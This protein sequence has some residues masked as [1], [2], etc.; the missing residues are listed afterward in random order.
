MC[1]FIRP[2]NFPVQLTIAPLIGAIAAG[3]PA[4]VKPSESTPRTAVIL[5]K[6]IAD[7]LEPSCYACVQGAIPETEALLKER[8]DKIFFTGS[9]GVGKII[10]KKAAETLTPVALE[11]GG[12]NPAIVT[13][14]A[15]PLLAAKRLAF[16]KVLNAGQVCLSHNYALV[17][18]R[19]FAPFIE[20]LKQALKDMYPNGAKSSPDLGRLV[21]QRSFDRVKKLLETTSG[22]VLV[23]G[24]LESSDFLV[25]PTILEVE[26]LNDPILANETF[27][28][29][30][31]VYA[32]NGV[33]EAIEV[34][35]SIDPTPLSLS[36]FGNDEDVEKGKKGILD[37]QM[38]EN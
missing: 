20:G 31:P 10:A 28:P 29:L 19:I 8:W 14:S 16:G 2:F 3:C 37:M 22:K 21:N 17:D 1:T 11:L 25:E 6:I 35:N 23:G 27:A 26:N 30:M 38:V 5:E 18:K 34:A 13:A 36:V 7:Y 33:D 4:V 32:V 9:P 15:D 12:R 24:T